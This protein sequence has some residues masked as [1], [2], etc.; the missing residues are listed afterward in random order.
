MKL[1]RQVNDGGTTGEKVEFDSETD[2][3]FCII[4]LV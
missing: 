4:K 3:E 1:T 2:A